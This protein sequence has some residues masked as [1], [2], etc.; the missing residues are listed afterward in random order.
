MFKE[1]KHH[2]KIIITLALILV[3]FL[4]LNSCGIPINVKYDLRFISDNNPQ[5]DQTITTATC[6]IRGKLNEFL[7]MSDIK[8][9]LY[10][11]YLVSSTD[12]A[13][14]KIDE[15]D[16]NR[17][18]VTNLYNTPYK[19]GTY[20]DSETMGF[21]FY[22]TDNRYSSKNY[23]ML[24]DQNGYRQTLEEKYNSLEKD[25]TLKYNKDNTLGIYFTFDDDKQQTLN[26]E[27]E[28]QNKIISTFDQT[29]NTITVKNET[30]NNE[31]ELKDFTGNNFSKEN[32]SSSTYNLDAV[33]AKKYYK[34]VIYSFVCSGR[35]SGS[36]NV[37]YSNMNK[38]AE[39]TLNH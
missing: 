16:L 1:K 25:P 27:V 14:I 9:Q 3:F 5:D 29:T 2:N 37:S 28:K 34:L 7:T 10:F 30:N 21:M 26:L 19:Q 20:V 8:P 39:F 36:T 11:M 18:I 4:S 22:Q 24:I 35:N 23:S 15:R 17:A 32:I 12:S 38:L 31:I 13:N 33:E 6:T